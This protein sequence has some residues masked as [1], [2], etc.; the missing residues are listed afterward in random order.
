MIYHCLPLLHVRFAIFTKVLNEMVGIER[1]AK[2]LTP[3]TSLTGADFR[4]LEGP[5]T[6]RADEAVFLQSNLTAFRSEVDAALMRL[7][8]SR[9]IERME[10]GGRVY[11]VVRTGHGSVQVQSAD[12]NRLVATDRSPAAPGPVA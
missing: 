2:S 1:N 7:T 6:A 5:G 4:V 9:D 12:R 8:P 10:F 3:L 11:R